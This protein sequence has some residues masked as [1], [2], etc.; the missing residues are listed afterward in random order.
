MFKSDGGFFILRNQKYYLYTVICATHK[1]LKP[2]SMFFS[3]PESFFTLMKI[4]VIAMIIITVLV[5]IISR[6]NLKKYKQQYEESLR[7]GD[8][9]EAITNGRKYYT[10][11]NKL[12]KQTQ[13]YDIEARINNDLK[14]QR[15]G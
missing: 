9:A 12:N 2:P 14:I 5:V 6:Q 10:A 13:I 8:Q 1:F 15:I 3:N 7:S 4:A 11:F